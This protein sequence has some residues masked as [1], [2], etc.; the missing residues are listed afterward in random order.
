MMLEDR[1]FEQEWVQELSNESF[2]MLL[3]LL[4]YASKKTGII[5]LNM[6]QINFAANTGRMFT[7]DDIL[8]EFGNMI[9]MLPGRKSTAIFPEYIAI[10][11]AKNGKPIDTV[12]N[13]LF[14]SIV[15]ELA[16]FGLTI[17]DVN[18]LSSKRITVKDTFEELIPKT[19]TEPVKVTASPS[20]N[21]D[22]MFDEF[23]KA[24]PSSCPRK[25]DKK[26]CRD[27][28]MNILKSS[29]DPEVMHNRILGGLE[30]WKVSDTW[31]KE[32]GQF[33]RA[34]MVWLNGRNW[35]DAPTK[36]GFNGNSKN[37]TANANYKGT[38]ANDIF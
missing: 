23:W 32:N 22:E 25:V 14:K 24:Y 2:R 33:I 29:K 27:K 1:F 16:S 4:H 13:P 38:G 18:K 26:K 5:E 9:K 20:V 3:Y 6:R 11:W 12:K 19:T 30:I 31:T 36:G 34:P 37:G 7:I 21:L 8:S 28:Y 35:E 15:Q 17:D 10:N